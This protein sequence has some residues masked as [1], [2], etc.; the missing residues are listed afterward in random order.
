MSQEFADNFVFAE[1]LDVWGPKPSR[2]SPS[3]IPSPVPSQGFDSRPSSTSSAPSGYS[4]YECPSPTYSEWSTASETLFQ[5]TQYCAVQPQYIGQTG[6]YN[7]PQYYCPPANAQTQYPM[8]MGSY[9]MPMAY[10][11]QP[12]P[13]QPQGHLCQRDANYDVCFCRHCMQKSRK[14]YR[15]N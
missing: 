9:G 1:F 13:Y 15:H 8:G 6:Y 11:P 7:Q 10:Q 4:S 3:V 14:P 12:A 2:A 5:P